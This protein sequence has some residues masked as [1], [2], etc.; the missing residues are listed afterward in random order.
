[1]YVSPV[2]LQAVPLCETENSRSQCTTPGCCPFEKYQDK[3]HCDANT[4]CCQQKANCDWLNQHIEGKWSGC[5][6]TCDMYSDY[7]RTDKIR[8]RE[9]VEWYQ[10]LRI[11]QTT[12][13]LT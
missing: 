3:L 1:M 8:L 6:N 5:C 10:Q 12:F 11:Y 9:K 7:Q 4:T 13:H 2:D